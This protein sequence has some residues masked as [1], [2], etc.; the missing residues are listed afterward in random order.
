MQAVILFY[1]PRAQRVEVACTR[2]QLST[3]ELLMQC[4]MELAKPNVERIMNWLNS[5]IAV[6]QNEFNSNLNSSGETWI[7]DIL[8]VLSTVHLRLSGKETFYDIISKITKNLLARFS[9]FVNGILCQQK[10]SNVLP[11]RL[12]RS[13]HKKLYNWIWMSEVVLY[14]DEINILLIL[15]KL[16]TKQRLKC[17][18]F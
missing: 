9:L 13:I 10:E 14:F 17:F 7:F 3:Q 11:E 18:V 15:S 6:K 4:L 2:K 5:K 1:F 8:K 12:I 16:L